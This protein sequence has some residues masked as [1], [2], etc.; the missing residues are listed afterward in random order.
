MTSPMRIMIY[1]PDGTVEV[2]RVVCE[3]GKLADIH[4]IVDPIIGEGEWFEHVTVFWQFM[5][6]ATAKYLDAFV[7]ENGNL[8]SLP[9]NR[10]ATEIYQ[11]NIRV[12]DPKNY[13][14]VRMPVIVGPMVLFEERVWL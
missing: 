12:H 9:V 5:H 10:A 6:S 13:D 14:P 3:P 8:L 11:N 1:R 7:N 2:D 4:R